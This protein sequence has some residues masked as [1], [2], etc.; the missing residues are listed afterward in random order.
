MADQQGVQFFGGRMQSGIFARHP[1]P[2]KSGEGSR[3][4]M[5]RLPSLINADRNCKVL[6]CFRGSGLQNN[7]DCF[8]ANQ[9]SAI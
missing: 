7:S 2:A 9:S 4:G 3:H 5:G 8:D 1:D 6:R